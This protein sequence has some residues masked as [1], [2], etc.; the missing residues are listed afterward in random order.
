MN[1][2]QAKLLA[3]IIYA[4]AAGDTIQIKHHEIC[5]VW[6]D[7]KSGEDISSEALRNGWCYRVAPK[8]P[9]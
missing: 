2:G 3:P 6:R 7:M 8:Q 9:K 1:R 4:F 5:P